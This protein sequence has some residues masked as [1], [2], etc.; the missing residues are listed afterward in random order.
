MGEKVLH[1]ASDVNCTSV[2]RQ[3]VQ[4]TLFI[5][6]VPVLMVTQC[7]PLLKVRGLLADP[8]R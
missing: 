5:F 2:I 8:Q 1:S 6:P 3:L 4:R 7:H